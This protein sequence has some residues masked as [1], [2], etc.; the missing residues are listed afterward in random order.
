MSNRRSKIKCLAEDD[1]DEIGETEDAARDG[2]DEYD[3]GVLSD[4]TSSIAELLREAAV[5]HLG[6]QD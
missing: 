6:P 5:Y 3:G 2:D 4:T 1:D